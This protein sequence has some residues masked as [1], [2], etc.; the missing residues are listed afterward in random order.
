MRVRVLFSRRA[1]LGLVAAAVAV[2]AAAVAAAE[3]EIGRAHV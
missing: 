1:F 2:P 3:L